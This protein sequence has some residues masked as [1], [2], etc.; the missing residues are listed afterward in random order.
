MLTQISGVITALVTPFLDGKI[1]FVSLEK[2]V[3]HQLEGKINGLVINGTTAESPTL[4]EEEVHQIFIFVRKIVGPNFPLILGT[5]TNSTEETILN[6]KKV[7]DWG[8]QAA[9]VVVPYYNKPPQ[10]GLIHHFKDVAEKSNA[11]VILYNVPGRTITSMTE[12]TILTLS[13]CKNIIGIKE[14]SGQID[15]DSSLKQK[16]SDSFIFLSGDDGTYL[17]FLD[18]GGHGVISVMSNLFPSI[19]T[20]WTREYLGENKEKIKTEFQRFKPL[21]DGMY[22]EANPIP[23]KWMLYKKNIIRSPELRLPLMTLDSKFHKS[24]EELLK[25][26]GEP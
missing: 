8:A 3:H 7:I 18:I 24:T 2:L 23:V 1:D 21:I 14:A 20:K 26:L 17:D 4:S 10:R 6:T 15:F 9:L 11:P 22:V 19:A 5:G 16:L 25:V 12:E 13:E